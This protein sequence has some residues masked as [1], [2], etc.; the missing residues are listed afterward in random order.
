M[1]LLKIK[2]IY[3]AILGESRLA[4]WPCTIVRLSGCHRRCV[5]CD[6]E[7]AFRGGKEMSVAT[8]SPAE[9]PSRAHHKKKSH[10]LL[11]DGP[12]VLLS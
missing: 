4:G 9:L 6:T 12:L 2:E 3:S 10:P 5:Y 7:Y 1:K 8:P 11:E